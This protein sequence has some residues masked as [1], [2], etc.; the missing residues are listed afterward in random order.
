MSGPLRWGI[1]G[2]AKFAREHM[3]PAIHEAEGAVLA[4]LATRDPARARPFQAMVP[5]IAV[6]D[7]YEALLG[8][9]DIDVV[10]IPLPNHMHVEW[11]LRALEAGK[12]VLVEKPAAMAE[13]EFDRLVAARDAA[14]RLAAEAYMIVHHP[15]WQKAR[16]LVREGALGRVM[17]VQGGFA[18]DIADAPD[19]IRNRPE[20]GG[21]ALRDIGVYPFG[22]TRFVMGA[23][24]ERLTADLTRENEVDVVAQVRADFPGFTFS[25]YLST[26]MHPRQEMV[27]HG[28][29]GVLRLSAPFNAGVF[30]QAQLHLMRAGEPEQVWRYV[31][32]RQYRLQ[33]EA[34]CRSVR[35]GVPYPVPLEWSR[36]T[37]AM[38]D[39]IYAAA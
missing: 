23:E 31:T 9:D 24:P 16:E 3:G 20:T 2:A 30:D 6:H 13:G 39:A 11:T 27:F 22:A 21:G 14:G 15:Q 38:I 37:Q 32:E 34:F 4:A 36:G 5:D 35:D 25:T 19:N 33:V 7:D 28:T 8:A 18:F 29:R 26:R 12:H 10:Y 1:L 17:H